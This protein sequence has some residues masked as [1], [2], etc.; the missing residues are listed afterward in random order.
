MSLLN[1]CLLSLGVCAFSGAATAQD[2]STPLAEAG[3]QWVY[4]NLET[5]STGGWSNQNGASLYGQYFFK[6]AGRVLHAR[7]TLGI[8]ADL[9]GSASQSGSLYTYLFGPRGQYGV[10]EVP[11]CF[12][13]RIQTRGRSCSRE[14]VDSRRTQHFRYTQQFYGRRCRRRARCRRLPPLCGQ[15]VSDRLFGCRCA[16]F[17][18]RRPLGGRHAYLGRHQLPFRPAIRRRLALAHCAC[19]SVTFSPT[20]ST[21]SILPESST[22]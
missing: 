11:P 15:P 12:S 13:C 22:R 5:S 2:D 10:A 17:L 4:N 14:W 20:Y 3:V 6:S 18:G 9:S 8:V 1:Y 21:I 16:A 19:L 7:T